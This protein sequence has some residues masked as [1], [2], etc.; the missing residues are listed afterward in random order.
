MLIDMHWAAHLYA[1][2]GIT[3]N[4]THGTCIVS[5]MGAGWLEDDQSDRLGFKFLFVNST[6]NVASKWYETFHKQRMT[7]A[8]YRARNSWINS[9][10]DN[11]ESSVI[12][13]DEL[14][15]PIHPHCHSLKRRCEKT[16]TMGIISPSM[17]QVVDWCHAAAVLSVSG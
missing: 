13:S 12:T 2:K 4:K 16:P 6:G 7:A 14:C 10:A 5:N 8:P 15:S 1:C 3:E 11:R 9:A 17:L